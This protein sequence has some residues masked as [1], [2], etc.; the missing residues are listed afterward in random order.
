MRSES[1]E[2]LKGGKGLNTGMTPQ[3][4]LAERE[5]D[6]AE[7]TL[8]SEG[9]KGPVCTRRG[10]RPNSGGQPGARDQENGPFVRRRASEDQA[11]PGRGGKAD[12]GVQAGPGGNADPRRS[13][14]TRAPAGRGPALG[15]GMV[16]HGKLRAEAKRAGTGSSGSFQDVRPEGGRGGEGQLQKNEAVTISQ[17]SRSQP[18]RDAQHMPTGSGTGQVPKSARQAAR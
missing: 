4:R 5:A 13:S 12:Q 9:L 17:K 18:A 2:A 14:R 11:A 1:R 10:R 15:T 3:E 6:K 16:R 7:V 8:Y